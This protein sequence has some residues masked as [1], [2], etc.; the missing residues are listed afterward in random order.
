MD[1]DVCGFKDVG[2]IFTATGERDRV[3]KAGPFHRFVKGLSIRS[4]LP[5]GPLSHE[6][7]LQPPA[8]LGGEAGQS[9]DH[10]VLPLPAADVADH[11]G[12]DLLGAYSEFLTHLLSGSKLKFVKL[13]QVDAW[14]GEEDPTGRNAIR[15]KRFLD[16]SRKREVGGETRH[17]EAACRTRFPE[18]IPHGVGGAG[19]SCQT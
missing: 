3:L 7:D 2:H 19:D 13:V 5:C 1:R 18:C 10:H 8:S 12:E 15:Q 11:H 9:L 16:I 14:I 6:E 4:M 17:R